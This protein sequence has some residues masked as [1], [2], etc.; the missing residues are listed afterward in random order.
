MK[1][2]PRNNLEIALERMEEAR[3]LLADVAMSDDD[4]HN[5]LFRLRSDLRDATESLARIV[6]KKTSEACK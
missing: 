1:S 4:T 5:I 6:K 3:R 2:R